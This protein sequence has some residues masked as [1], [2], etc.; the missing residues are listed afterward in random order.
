MKFDLVDIAPGTFVMGDKDAIAKDEKMETSIEI[1]KPFR[2]LRCP[3]TQKQWVDVMRNKP[4][5][6]QDV[7]A[8]GGFVEGQDYPA[9]GV[10]RD[11][12]AKF[13]AALQKKTHLKFALPTEAQWEYAIRAGTHTKYFWGPNIDD[14]PKYAWC[15]H[16]GALED[17]RLKE[18][19]R[20]KPNPWGLY[21][22]AGNVCEWVRDKCDV[23]KGSFYIERKHYP[24]A[25]RDFY[26]KTGKY[27]ILRNGSFRCSSGCL[28]SSFKRVRRL[29]DVDV[30][31][32]FRIVLEAP[33]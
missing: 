2:M 27:G 24:K 32:G 30:F 25:A 18:V 31:N 11:D 12:I 22:M 19:G 33:F 15:R 7:K 9:V 28:A 5:S 8:D 10:N 1:T 16:Q 6:R 4:W 17:A 20:L 29:D 21:D 3:V 13:L 14:S 26:S 23:G